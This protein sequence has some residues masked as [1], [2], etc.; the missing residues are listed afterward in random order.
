MKKKRKKLNALK[1][2]I[3]KTLILTEFC[4]ANSLHIL[5]MRQI[6]FLEKFC[7]AFVMQQALLWKH[8]YVKLHKPYNNLNK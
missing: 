5:L 4:F 8:S 2:P 3:L 7:I 6:I 1:I